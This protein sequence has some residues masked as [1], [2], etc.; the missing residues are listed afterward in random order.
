MSGVAIRGRL[1]WFTGEMFRHV[2]D[3]LVVCADGMIT[4]VGTWPAVRDR[5]PAGTAVHHYPGHVVT[6]GFVDCHTHYSQTAVVGAPADDLPRWLE[7]HAYPEERRF[8]DP[9]YAAAVADR[10]CAELLRNGTTTCLAYCTSAPGSVD[11]LCTAA[12]GRNMRVV[13]GKVLMDRA[14]PPAVRD[15]AERGY[16]ES[17]ALADR[18]HG[19]GRIGYAI[20][21][22]YAPG[23]TV[24]QLEAA[25]ALHRERPEL[26]VH[27]H[28]AETAD[29]VD[30]VLRLFPGRRDYLDV[31]EHAGLA[32]DTTV[33]AHGVHLTRDELRRCRAALVHCPTS[34]AFLGSGLF[35]LAAAESAGVRV[36]LGTDIGAGTSFSLPR[37]MAAAHDTA[38]L[39]GHPLDPVHGLYLATLGGAR[40]I[41]LA[42]RVGSLA[43]GHEADV[44]VLDPAA[45]PALA[46]RAAGAESIGD[47]LAALAVLGDDRAVRA[48]YLAGSPV[49]QSS[50][51]GQVP[52][53]FS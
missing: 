45:T 41:G 43:P 8:A 19:R 38:M 11:A 37:M 28:I 3:G 4:A 7:R 49:G 33:F 27:S 34:N 14:G 52:V 5:V 15:T 26:L 17:A 16:A 24:A 6:A 31:F 47:L 53:A 48:T 36:G 13:A 10:F 9:E 30:E 32:D 39:R 29:E 12:I 21:P 46:R 35:D 18:W 1:C 23:S 42:D 20:T 50:S 2:E 44:V 22:R 25:A 51:P 40:A